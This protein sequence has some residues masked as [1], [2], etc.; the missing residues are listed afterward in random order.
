[1]IIYLIGASFTFVLMLSIFLKDR[2]TPKTDLVSWKLLLV[3]ALLWFVILPYVLCQRWLMVIG[4]K[5]R[6]A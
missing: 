5:Q 1:M 6:P 4:K 2:S 3:S